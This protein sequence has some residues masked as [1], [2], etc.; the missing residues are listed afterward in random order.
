M[1]GLISAVIFIITTTKTIKKYFVEWNTA[2]IKLCMY[3]YI[4]THGENKLK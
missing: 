1:N 2:E 4:H 3:I